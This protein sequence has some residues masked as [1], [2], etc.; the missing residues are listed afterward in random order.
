[1]V[2][3]SELPLGQRLRLVHIDG[4]RQLKQRLM[5]LGIS[6]GGELRIVQRRPGGVVVARSGSRVALGQ[7]IAH[8]LMAEVVDLLRARG[9]VVVASSGNDGESAT[10]SPACLGGV[11][12][13]GAVESRSYSVRAA[14]A[15]SGP[16]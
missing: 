3:L 12:A 10:G 7:G 1:M 2:R 5:A 11:V 15:A 16:Q 6:V 9:T 4:G 14:R 13:V 8:K